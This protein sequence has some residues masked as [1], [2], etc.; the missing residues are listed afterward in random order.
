MTVI[1]KAGGSRD[2]RLLLLR[3]A[4]PF[5]STATYRRFF[6]L[7]GAF[8]S[9]ARARLF[10]LAQPGLFTCRPRAIPRPSA[11]TFS[12]IVE[13]AATYAPSPIFT[14][15]TSAESLPM[16][17]LFPIVVGCLWNPS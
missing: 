6:R 5:A 11:G 3:E 10:L 7:P 13:P 1:T 12:V 17:T 8:F 9:A 16:N 14:G 4:Q 15:A 2:R